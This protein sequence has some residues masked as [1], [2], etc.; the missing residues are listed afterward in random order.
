MHH[1]IKPVATWG[2]IVQVAGYGNHLF[3]VDAYD[4]MYRY[5][6]DETYTEILYDLT[7]VFGDSGYIIGEQDEVTLVCRE[8]KADAFLQAYKPVPTAEDKPSLMA[9]IY[10]AIGNGGDTDMASTKATVKVPTKQAQIDTL[11]DELNDV[12]SIM[13][14][15]GDSDGDYQRKIDEINAKLAE[16]LR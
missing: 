5:E 14:T 12:R 4:Y 1:E 3:A 10:Y 11:L 8:A 2:D 16:V 9:Q 6:P 13:A 15:I 7:C